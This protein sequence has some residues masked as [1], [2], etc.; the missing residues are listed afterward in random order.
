M[1]QRFVKTVGGNPHRRLLQQLSEE[2]Q[3]V[4]DLEPEFE[5][6]SDTDLPARTSEFKV[7]IRTAG[8]SIA[9][10]KE[11][12]AAE[13]AALE[14]L[15]PQA[16]A[17][18][19]EA[20]K[21]T[22]GLRHYDVQLI[23]GVVLHRGQIAEM[24]T[25]EGKTLVATLAA[26]PQCTDRPRHPPGHRQR[27]SRPPRCPLDGA[28]LPY[29]RPLRR[30]PANGRRHRERQEGLPRRFLEGV[31]A[32]GPASSAHGGPRRSLRRRHHLRHQLRVRLRLSARQHDHA[33]R[34]PRPARSSLRHR[35]RGR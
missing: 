1:L 2:I 13:Q 5:R 8:E 14:E 12:L 16:F 3:A 23:G 9:D 6:L 33:P 7:A 28:H 34:G 20:A 27:L 22:I 25:G 30:R 31:A 21:R 29:P 4:N 35:R 17:L 32:R 19:R 18:V 11:R 26:L 24:K 15:L 10:D